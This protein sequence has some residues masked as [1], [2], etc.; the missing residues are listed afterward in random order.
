MSTKF[1]AFGLCIGCAINQFTTTRPVDHVTT[2]ILWLFVGLLG[3]RVSTL[4][5][6]K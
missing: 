5:E 6:K 2:G 1:V 3:Y 4:E